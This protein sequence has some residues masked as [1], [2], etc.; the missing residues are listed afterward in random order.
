MCIGL[1]EMCFRYSIPNFHKNHF[2]MLDIILFMLLV[3]IIILYFV[4]C[5]GNKIYKLLTKTL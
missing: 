2:I 1:N 5:N 3:V 4:P